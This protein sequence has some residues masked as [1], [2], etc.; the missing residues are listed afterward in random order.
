MYIHIYIYIYMYVYRS[1]HRK[2]TRSSREQSRFARTVG[3]DESNSFARSKSH[4]YSQ[5][6][7]DIHNSHART[8]TH[9]H[10]HTPDK[11]TCAHTSTNV[12]QRLKRGAELSDN[13]KLTIHRS[14][15]H[16]FCLSHTHTHEITHERTHTN[17]L[18]PSL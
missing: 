8:H 10:P 12:R 3:A 13:L 5:H 15:T 1:H 11:Y 17:I 7:Y 4:I 16:A 6:L 18:A 9:T 14:H 2:T